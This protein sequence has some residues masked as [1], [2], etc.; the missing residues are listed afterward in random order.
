MNILLERIF[1]N[2]VFIKEKLL[3]FGFLENN[4]IL[5][6]STSLLDKQFNLIV[7]IKGLKIHSAVLFDNFSNEEYTLHLVESAEGK[8]VG[9]VREEYERILNDIS[10]KCCEK[11]HF[12]FKQTV[13]ISEWINNKYNDNPEFLWEK[14]PNYA[15]FRN[16]KTQKWYAL[17]C[18]IDYSKIDKNKSGKIEIINL[19]TDKNTIKDFLNLEG[20]FPAYHMNKKTWISLVLDGTIKNDCIKE[21]IDKSYILSK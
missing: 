1:N 14:F 5:T 19:K 12:S 8:F 13:M 16:S 11:I 21:L 6:Y 9:K 18:D 3:Q 15:V 4:E 10:N 17:I 2:K 20:F 7:V